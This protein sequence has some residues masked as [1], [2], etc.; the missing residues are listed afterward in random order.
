MHITVKC[1]FLW[2]FGVDKRKTL[3]KDTYEDPLRG[4]VCSQRCL[5]G[6]HQRHNGKLALFSSY[7]IVKNYLFDF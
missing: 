6:Q 7:L 2:V 4:T 3:F 5:W 1:K